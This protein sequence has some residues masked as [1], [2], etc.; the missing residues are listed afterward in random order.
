MSD[1]VKNGIRQRN[2]LR[3][4]IRTGENRKRWIDKCKEVKDQIKA[5]KESKWREYVEDLEATTNIKEVWR[6]ISNLD[7]RNAPR[8]ENEILVVDERVHRG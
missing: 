3:K 2:K 1:E 4:N 7:G 5:E 6:V 8:K